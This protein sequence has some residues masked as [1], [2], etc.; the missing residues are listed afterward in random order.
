M[1]LIVRTDAE[2]DVAAGHGWYEEQQPGLGVIFVEE[3]SSSINA[4]HLGPMRFPLVFKVRRALVHRFPYG[5]FFVSTHEAIIVVAAIH[6]ARDP[7]RI[8][9]ASK[10]QNAIALTSPWTASAF[11]LRIRV[12][13]NSY[14]PGR[15]S[16]PTCASSLFSW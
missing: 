13:K 4:I 9:R 10:K 1:R 5:I 16:C 7:R 12:T 2:A 14:I 8:H 3:V 11:L 6:L 15:D